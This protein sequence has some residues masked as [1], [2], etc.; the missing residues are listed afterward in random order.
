MIT[1]DKVSTELLPTPIINRELEELGTDKK[2]SR[3]MM[4]LFELLMPTLQKLNSAYKELGVFSFESLKKN[5]SSE[6]FQQRNIAAIT[7]LGVSSLA[8]IGDGIK[9]AVSSVSSSGQAYFQSCI[10]DASTSKS[11]NQDQITRANQDQSTLQ[12]MIEKL[13]NLVQQVLQTEKSSG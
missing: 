5:N 11:I 3:F 8:P 7:L 9:G 13:L 1:L 2:V 4:E 6:N 12:N 10:G